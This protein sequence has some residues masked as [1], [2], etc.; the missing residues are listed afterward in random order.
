MRLRHLKQCRVDDRQNDCDIVTDHCSYVLVAPERQHPLRHLCQQF[1]IV[2]SVTARLGSIAWYVFDLH[3]TQDHQPQS[4]TCLGCGQADEIR[5]HVM[6]ECTAP[7]DACINHSDEKDLITFL[8]EEPTMA[9][10]YVRNAGF[11]EGSC[12]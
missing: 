6:T 4:A 5:T 7:E 9:I 12:I 1:H 10:N 11:S 8:F 3:I 2:L